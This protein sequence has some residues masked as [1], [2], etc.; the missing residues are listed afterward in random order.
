MDIIK[1]G[2]K[3][4]ENMEGINSMFSQKMLTSQSFKKPLKVNFT[5]SGSSA[6]SKDG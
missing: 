4:K 6:N 1:K 2:E 3:R 5:L